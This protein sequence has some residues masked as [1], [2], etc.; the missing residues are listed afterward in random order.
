MS[1]VGLSVCPLYIF[2]LS[3]YSSHIVHF[4]ILIDLTVYFNSLSLLD[5][6]SI[7]IFKSLFKF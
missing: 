4:D 2:S 3:F 5:L 1:G 7:S 6:W